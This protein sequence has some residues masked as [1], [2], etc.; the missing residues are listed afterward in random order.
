IYCGHNEF[1]SRLDWGRDLDHYFDERLPTVWSLLLERVEATSPLCGL[2]RE[3]ADKCRIA[4][5]PPRQGHRSLVDVPAYSAT[6]ARILLVDFRRRLEAIV[7]YAE[8]LG[9]L[10]VLIAPPGNDAGFEPNRSFLP[11][12]TPRSEREAFAREFRAARQAEATDPAAAL[13]AYRSLLA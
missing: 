9:A 6:E 5:P 1:S 4:I 8:R 12:A 2:I 10:P 11:A 13:A 7:S 3:T